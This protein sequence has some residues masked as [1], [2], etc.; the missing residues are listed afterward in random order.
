MTPSRTDAHPA[1]W[2]SVIAG[3]AGLWLFVSPWIYGAEGN[4]SAWNSWIVGAL[5]VI[6]AVART[7]HPATTRLSWFNFVLGIW[8][9]ISPWIYGYAG[10]GG[11]FVNNLCVGV[12]VFCLAIIGA[13]SDRMSHHRTSTSS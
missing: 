4:P 7:T 9:F 6:F 10:G 1:L 13:T 12:I 2:A 5:I 8:T 3:L 11:R